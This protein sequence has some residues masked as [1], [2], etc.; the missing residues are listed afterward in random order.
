[1]SPT[2]L[3]QD[4]E[5]RQTT[6]DIVGIFFVKQHVFVLTLLGIIV[7]ALA[8]SLLTPPIYETSAQLVVKP[9]NSKPLVFDQ[10]SSRMNVVSEV[11]E[12]TLNT[13]IFLLTSPEVLREVVL[14]HELAP[15]DDNEK[16]LN[17]IE[18]LKGRIKAEPLT[19]SSIV[20]VSMKGRDPQKITDE[21]NTLIDAY[22]R[23]HIRVNQATEG[24]LKFFN[25]QTEYFRAQLE[26][27]S[28]QLAETGKR[29]DIIDPNLQKD[30]SL[31]LIR[32]LE[33]SKSQ[34]NTQAEA[35]RAKTESIRA[36]LARF[37]TEERLAGLPTE[38]IL[39]YPALVEMEKSLAQLLI[40]RQRA[41][42]DFLPSSKQ[43]Q[44]AENQYR[45][46]KEQIRRYM[47]QIISDLQTQIEFI[48]RSMDDLDKKILIIRKRGVEMTGDMLEMDRLALEHKLIKEN[49][50]LYSAKK[51]E[52][53][54]NEEKDKAQFANVSV[55]NRPNLP[56]SP[57]FPQR[58]KI[59]ALS[60]PLALMLAFAFSAMSY[61]T[62]QRLWT[63][64]D[65]NLHTDLRVLGSLDSVGIASESILRSR[66]HTGTQAP[67][68]QTQ[69]AT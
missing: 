66:K 44:D 68:N 1:M 63:P 9:Y 56:I 25:D 4:R 65:I 28:N 22:I 20:K 13:V 69:S 2:T 48:H 40:N 42:G 38:T 67:I 50:T 39:A 47:E 32:D 10:D 52:A 43:V 64:T 41:I 30:S 46:M 58:G 15:A 19:M 17:E 54:I 27:L 14:H 26:K 62:E 36:A 11:N 33:V 5:Y 16:I 12:Q 55:A 21:L 59:I 6:R 60:I 34:L 8:V 23:H 3:K 29:L 45:A 7:G 35:L 18:A 31:M 49:Y 51:E 57:W 24:R 61:A 37:R 53:R